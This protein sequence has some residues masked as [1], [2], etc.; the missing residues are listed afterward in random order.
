MGGNAPLSP[1]ILC[2][3]FPT[4][5]SS[6]NRLIRLV[7]VFKLVKAAA[8]IATGIGI[9]KLMHVDVAAALND[10]IVRLGLDPG[11]HY[12]SE[13]WRRRLGSHRTKSSSW[14]W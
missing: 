8:L 9:L 5:R 1:L 4:M 13:C 3:N 14:G 10:W 11:S 12:V 2:E 7:A 6:N